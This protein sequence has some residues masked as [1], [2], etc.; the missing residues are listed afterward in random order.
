MR[1][2]LQLPAFLWRAL[3]GRPVPYSRLL[4]TG[5]S[6]CLGRSVAP[7]QI[8]DQPGAADHELVAMSELL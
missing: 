1:R 5:P 7:R 8:D 2:S 4:P 3:L 6:C